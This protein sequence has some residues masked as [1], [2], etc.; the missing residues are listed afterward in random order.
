MRVNVV[1]R[2]LLNPSFATVF[3]HMPVKAFARYQQVFVRLLRPGTEKKEFLPWQTDDGLRH[4]ADNRRIGLCR[5]SEFGQQ[6][7]LFFAV[8]FEHL[9]TPVEL[10]T[11]SV[12]I[13]DLHSLS[14][15]D[16]YLS[17]F[18]T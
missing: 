9:E 2:H 17:D 5:L 18:G 14:G 11:V 15:Y 12:A 3:L 16:P 4:V 1:F 10:M 8:S 7:E 13:Q 6:L